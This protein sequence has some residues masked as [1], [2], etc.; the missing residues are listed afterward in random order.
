MK[1]ASMVLGIVGG[2]LALFSGLMLILM[3][4]FFG[5]GFFGQLNLPSDF[6][7]EIFSTVFVTLWVITGIFYLTG[8]AAGLAGGIIVK[9]KNVAGGVLLIV[10]AVLTFSIP[11]IL[12]AIF[13]FVKEKGPIPAPI[14]PPLYPPYTPPYPPQ[15][16]Q[17]S[18]QGPQ[19]PPNEPASA[20]NRPQE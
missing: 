7:V 20:E 14:Y 15:T 5:S 17:A 1:T 6:P 16:P 10:G 11:L 3:G 13:A 18:P 9:N 12:A 2:A 4:S 19:V 8:G